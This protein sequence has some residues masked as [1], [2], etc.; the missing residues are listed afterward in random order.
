MVFRMGTPLRRNILALSLYIRRYSQASDIRQ[1]DQAS[2]CLF[3][4]LV[5]AGPSAARSYRR[6]AQFVWTAVR[7]YPI[8]VRKS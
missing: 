3:P 5:T 4:R 6:Y 8:L 2:G 1:P 7:G